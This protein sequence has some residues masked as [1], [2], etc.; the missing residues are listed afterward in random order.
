MTKNILVKIN[1]KTY[2]K[3]RTISLLIIK[4]SWLKKK[5]NNSTILT[6]T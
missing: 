5:I 1:K 3:N 4:I 6:D 2:I